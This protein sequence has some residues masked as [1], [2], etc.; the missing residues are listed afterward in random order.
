MGQKW[1]A[2]GPVH[3]NALKR[4]PK[5]RQSL[6]NKQPMEATLSSF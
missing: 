5:A 2:N 3:E 1:K 4:V 6:G